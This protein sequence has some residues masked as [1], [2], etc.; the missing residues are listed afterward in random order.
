MK[1]KNSNTQNRFSFPATLTP[2]LDDGGYV[3]TFRDL[4]EAITQGDSIESALQEAFDC[5]EEA[6]AARIDDRLNIPKPSELLE[7]EYLVTVPM[8][9]ALKAALVM[10]MSE[11]K[12]NQVQLA[13]ALN[14]DEKEVRRILDPHH[15][16]KLSTMER[17]L[18]VLGK[19]AVLYVE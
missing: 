16:T 1:S 7:N 9:T 18:N 3:V 13:Y 12:M 11:S 2:D 15:A 4:P 14:V 6:I 8:Q 19:K 5:I 10:A 17:T